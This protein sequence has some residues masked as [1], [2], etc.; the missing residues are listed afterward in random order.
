MNV[1]RKRGIKQRGRELLYKF[2][3][4]LFFPFPNPSFSLPESPAKLRCYFW[5]AI[6]RICPQNTAVTKQQ[7][8][9]KGGGGGRKANML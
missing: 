1:Q 7:A 6:S 8:L 4:Y 2:Y 5:V 3:T 9:G